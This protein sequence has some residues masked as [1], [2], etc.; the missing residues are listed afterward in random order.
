MFIHSLRSLRTHHFSL[1]QELDIAIVK[2]T[3]HVERPSK[4]KYIIGI[5]MSNASSRFK[6]YSVVHNC[7][8]NKQ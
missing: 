7:V 6:L 3:N 2:A 1:Q 4:E 5:F 8:L